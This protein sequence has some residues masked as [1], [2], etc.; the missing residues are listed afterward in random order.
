MCLAA[1]STYPT[2]A[3]RVIV[4]FAPGGQTDVVARLLSQKLSE[5]LGQQLY[6][7]NKPG[8]GGNIGTGLTARGADCNPVAITALDQGWYDSAGTHSPA[9]DNYYARYGYYYRSEDPPPAVTAPGQETRVG[10]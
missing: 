8:A 9:N 1:A 6:V 7:E 3:V 4:P 2:R 5:H 10:T